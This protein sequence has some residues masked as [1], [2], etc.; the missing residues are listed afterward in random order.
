MTEDKTNRIETI[1][2]N[3]IKEAKTAMVNDDYE[4][5]AELLQSATQLCWR[6]DT[7]KKEEYESKMDSMA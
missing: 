4:L 6:R 5:A 3:L 1:I 2:G 7:R